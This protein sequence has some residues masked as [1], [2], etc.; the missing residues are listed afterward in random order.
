[1]SRALLTGAI[2]SIYPGGSLEKRVG[3]EVPGYGNGMSSAKAALKSIQLLAVIS[4]TM[5]HSFIGPWWG[6]TFA[7]I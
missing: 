3:Y 2:L 4:T 5:S 7:I 1:L 6:V